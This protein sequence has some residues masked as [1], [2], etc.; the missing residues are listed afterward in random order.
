MRAHRANIYLNNGTLTYPYSEEDIIEFEYN[1]HAPIEK[2]SNSYI[3]MYEDGVPSA[4]MLYTTR[5]GNL[6]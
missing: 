2:K 1:I 3:A 4:A 6:N 5:Q